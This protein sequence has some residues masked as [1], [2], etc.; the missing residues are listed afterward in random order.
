MAEV[1][2][3]NLASEKATEPKVKD[4]VNTAEQ[5]RKDHT[6]A[7]EKLKALA[8]SKSIKGEE[9]YRGH[10]SMFYLAEGAA[11]HVQPGASIINTSFIDA[12][13]PNAELLPYATTKGA[14]AN[15]TVAR[16]SCW[17]RAAFE[18]TAWRRD[19]SGLH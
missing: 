7:N 19:R 15:F 13:S 11:A 5:Q 8:D 1:D 17:P 18:S 9:S 6:A 14:T 2:A 4:S 3:G 12:K 10:D 16:P